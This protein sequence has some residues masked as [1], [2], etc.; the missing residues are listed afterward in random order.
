MPL[1]LILS[2]GLLCLG[3]AWW[4]AQ[5]LQAELQAA[6]T[7]A[8]RTHPRPMLRKLKAEAHGLDLHLSGVVYRDADKVE[9]TRWLEEHIS[10]NGNAFRPRIVDAFALEA[11]PDG[12]ALLL[13]DAKGVRLL[14]RA[15]SVAEA[16]RLT[17]AVRSAGLLGNDLDA[18]D[19]EVDDEA[20][21]ESAALEA[22][23]SSVPDLTQRKAKPL[24]ASVTLGEPWRKLDTALPFDQL[25]G[26]L[27]PTA[28]AADDTQRLLK[29][30]LRGILDV[31]ETQRSVD[32]ERGRQQSL[33]PGHIIVAKRA[34]A[35]LLLGSLGSEQQLLDLKSKLRENGGRVLDQLSASP[36]RKPTDAVDSLGKIL[37]PLPEL[38]PDVIRIAFAG[39]KQWTTLAHSDLDEVDPA[40]QLMEAMGAER[41][42]A[43]IAPDVKQVL[44]WLR[45]VDS[46][47][48]H[49]ARQVGHLWL[50][51]AGAGVQL[52][53][54][55]PDE[56]S[57]SQLEQAVRQRYSQHE[58]KAE[59][60][61]SGSLQP[62][63][64]ILTTCT[65]FPDAPAADTVGIVAMAQP[66][67]SWQSQPAR[68][69]VFTAAGLEHS[70]LLPAGIS[71]DQ[72]LP[73]V[74]LSYPVARDHIQAVLKVTHGIPQQP[75]GPGTR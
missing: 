75:I 59:L 60:R 40:P 35:V 71:V 19:L 34:D 63:G 18:N 66:G 2:W 50:V 13:A 43:L 47:A 37:R 8:V 56:A 26:L 55:V 27:P 67:D 31:A 61:V 49:P 65:S 73:D 41:P 57:R 6:A 23:L 25:I 24:L 74:L 33:P 42:V 53:G 21:A 52:Y 32:W 9:A 51:I 22:S 45:S 69:L 30:T 3:G 10:L 64:P 5:G 17:E 36:N 46:W 58:V 20:L 48:P 15:A 4:C 28:L 54:Q 11:M 1:A 7:S 29:R 68:E 70:K 44:H 14:G 39:D 16:S 12:W 72:V 38:E 62:C